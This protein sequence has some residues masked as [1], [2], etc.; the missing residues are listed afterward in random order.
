MAFLFQFGEL[1]Q[2]AEDNNNYYAKI[3]KCY[4]KESSFFI[5]NQVWYN[6]NIYTRNFLN[7][8]FISRNHEGIRYGS[9]DAVFLYRL[10]TL[11]NWPPFDQEE[12]GYWPK[13]ELVEMLEAAEW[14]AKN[15]PDAHWVV[16][17]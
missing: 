11:V 2:D 6:V 3:P 17:P 13:D 16:M 5:N 1:K 7:E 4:G 12:R 14:A 15:I 8:T 10:N 9:I